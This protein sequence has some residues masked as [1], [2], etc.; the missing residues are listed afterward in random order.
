M[1][2]EKQVFPQTQSLL[3]PPLLQSSQ[4]KSTVEPGKSSLVTR[5]GKSVPGPSLP[6]SERSPAE[7]PRGGED[8]HQLVGPLSTDLREEAEPQL[9]EVQGEVRPKGVDQ[10]QVIH[11]LLGVVSQ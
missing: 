10:D 9:V 7:D 11:H 8:H 6:L 4:D 3:S 2:I 1:K 5:S